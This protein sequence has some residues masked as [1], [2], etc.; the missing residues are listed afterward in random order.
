M[1]SRIQGACESATHR[2]PDCE[3][4][5]LDDCDF[6]RHGVQNGVFT[7]SCI[8]NYQECSI[9]VAIP[10]C[11]IRMLT[12]ERAVSDRAQSNIYSCSCTAPGLRP[13]Q[14]TFNGRLHCLRG[15]FDRTSDFNLQ[16]PFRRRPCRPNE[17]I[18]RGEM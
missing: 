17:I 2:L 10:K 13:N 4:V 18:M 14:H 15:Y 6:V 3:T 8:D 16:L 7:P 12:S 9:N 1:N 11:W 5:K